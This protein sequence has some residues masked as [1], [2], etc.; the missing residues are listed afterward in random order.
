MAKGAARPPPPKPPGAV[1]R[2]GKGKEVSLVLYGAAAGAVVLA[3][4]IYYIS[5][6]SSVR[7]LSPA[8]ADSLKSVFFSG[9]PW[10]VECTAARSGHRV[11]YEAEGLLPKG[12]NAALLDCSKTLPSGKTTLDRFK[13]KATQ[14]G[15]TILMFSNAD[16]PVLAPIDSIR[17]GEDLAKWAA[18]RA[19]PRTLAA[20]SPSLF[21]QHC[22]R[23][24]LCAL[25]ITSFGKLSD[26]DKAALG[27]LALAHRAVRFVTLDASKMILSASLEAVGGGLRARASARA[28]RKSPTVNAAVLLTPHS[29]WRVRECV[30]GRGVRQ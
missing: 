27:A 29:Q 1:K 24:K 7:T 13:L 19:K 12:L 16:R 22:A 15:P 14:R 6:G 9:E 17:T 5:F 11:L 8:D 23:R 4:A 10:L 25:V 30:S 2:G 3:A 26:V 18:A 21:D 28:P 20:T